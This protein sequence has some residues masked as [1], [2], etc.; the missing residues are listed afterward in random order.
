MHTPWPMQQTPLQSAIYADSPKIIESLIAHGA[1]PN[2]MDEWSQVPIHIAVTVGQAESV[3]ALLKGGARVN[4]P[5]GEDKTLKAMLDKRGRP[6]DKEIV[7]GGERTPLHI[8]VY[9]QMHPGKT[10]EV[11]D[12]LLEGGADLQAK[13]HFGKTALMIALENNNADAV[14]WL[15]THGA[16]MSS[17]DADGTSFLHVVCSHGVG[18]KI[19]TT[20]AVRLDYARR[21]IASGV[22]VNARDKYGITARAYA[23]G[24]NWLE[25]ATFLK[26]HGAE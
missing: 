13:T 26:E 24:N 11:L 6:Y 3:R 7:R 4:E 2:E 22:D 18:Y 16:K 14:D 5:E 9:A 12:A 21:A 19:L 20:P 17:I 8:A 1:D 10:V 25:L 15:V 23:L